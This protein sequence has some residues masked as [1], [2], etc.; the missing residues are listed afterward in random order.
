MYPVLVSLGSI[1]IYSLSIFLLL[2]WLAFSFVFWK[3]LR[4]Q[5]VEE[6][7]IFDF[8][9]YS[10]VMAFLGA[11]VAF[12]LLHHELFVDT[13]LKIVAVWV[14]PGLSLYGALVAGMLTILFLSRRYKVRAGYI[15]D[16]IAFALPPALIVGLIGSFLDGT[17]VGKITSLPWG[18]SYIG[19]PGR[20]HPVQI[21]EIFA[22][23]GIMLIILLIQKRANKY[24]LPYG[25]TGLWF[26]F[27]Y[28]ISMFVIEFAKEGGVYF[29]YLSANQWVL[30]GF[31]AET[32]GAFYV[33]GGGRELVRPALRQVGER[34]QSFFQRFYAK[35]SKRPPH[36]DTET[37]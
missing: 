37:S 17:T 14:Q 34:I 36:R 15:L 4:N 18:A 31:F 11:R 2:A 7:R 28:S 22:L 1:H 21:Y 27:F 20:R 32:L 26:F 35:F 23:L 6:E 33:R 24:G 3:S 10:T 16:A 5:A 12:V 25:I 29:S 30:V 13:F 19:F 9:F 8:T